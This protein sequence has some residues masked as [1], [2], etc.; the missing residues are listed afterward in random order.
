[1]FSWG[2]RRRQLLEEFEEHIALETQENVDAGMSHEDARRAAMRKFGSPLAAA[3]ASR[4][5]WGGVWMERLIQDVRYA[6]RSLSA[7][8]A[9]TLTLVVT[10]ALGLGSVTAMLAIVQSILIRPVELPH[11]EELV[12]I[13]TESG[14]SGR[15]ASPRALSY[16]AIDALRRNTRSFAGIGGYNTMIRPVR[17]KDSTR[18]T[19]IVEVTPEFFLMLGVKARV[20]NTIGPKDVASQGVMVSDEFWRDRLHADPQVVGS[21]LMIDGQLRAVVGVL[22]SGAHVPLGT[23]GPMIYLPIAVKASGEDEFGVESAATIARLKPGVTREQALADAGSVFEHTERKHAEQ[24]RHLAIRSYR[25]LIVN[26]MERPLLALLGGVAVLLLIACANAANLQIGRAANR[27][28]EMSVRSALG[29]SFGRL[30]Q[31]LVTESVLLSLTGAA[32]GGGL[33]YAAIAVVRRTYGSEFPRFDELAVRPGVIVAIA[34]LAV[35][36]GVAATIAPMVTIRRQIT[37]QFA[38]KNMTR[39][40]RV[41]GLLVALQV[42]LTCVLLVVSGLFVRTLQ[43][44][45]NVKLGFDPHGVTTLT[46]MPENQKQDAIRSRE[47]AIDL[48]HRF[49]ALPGV[50]SVTMQ[51]EIPFSSYNMTL[52]GTTEVTGRPFHS[53]DSSFYSLVSTNFVRTSGIRLLQGRGFEQADES[54]AAIVALVNEAFVKKYLNGRDTIGA[55]LHFHREKGEA[56]ADLPFTQPI[57]VVGVVENEIQGGDLSAPYNPM[58]YLNNLQL[59]ASSFLMQVFNMTAQ[60]AVRSSL[61]QEAL[62]AE[63]RGVLHKDAPGMVEMNL[64]TM[65]DGIENSLKQRRLALRLVASFGAAA[66][67]LS[68]VGIYG[69]LA[70]SVA[71]RRR[72]IGIRMALG[73]TRPEAAALVIRQ[74]GA[75]VLLGLVPGLAGAWAAGYAVRS[76]LYGVKPLDGVTL[77]T[78]GCALL[79]VAGCAATIPAVRAAAVDPMEVLRTE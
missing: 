47:T 29:A 77:V 13:Y 51:T 7:V 61:S 39:R 8:P 67:V 3:E 40:S 27:M 32:L 34:A 68:A 37:A 16:P 57:T 19:L 66:L 41:P 2:R 1:M 78:V 42:A 72:E 26:D 35:L 12:Q 75:M 44:L 49:E 48:L 9:Y 18:I 22:P 65:E 64:Q 79:L 6:L 54:S 36:V 76:F 62:F 63:L 23:G 52:N 59:P 74:S 11:P 5:V 56:D 60:Y 43:S 53:G 28:A 15:A 55:T 21:T 73:S 46:A 69:V 58:V 70:Y 14:A 38:S 31:Q 4:E 71:R 25:S 33:A 10:L 45:Q 50:Q 24:S 20:G 30:L 17:T